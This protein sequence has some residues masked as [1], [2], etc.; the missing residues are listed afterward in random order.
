MVFEKK[1]THHIHDKPVVDIVNRKYNLFI[2]ISLPK[3]FEHVGSSD[4]F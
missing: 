3:P 4:K 1:I 2:F